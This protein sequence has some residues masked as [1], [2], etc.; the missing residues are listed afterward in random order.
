MT[1]KF[2]L[3]ILLWL[4]LLSPQLAA[5][6]E[7]NY[8][9]KHSGFSAST[10]QQPVFWLDNDRVIF[11]GH[12]VFPEK[13]R[14]DADPLLEQ[15]I[16]IWDTRN[17][18]V[19]NFAK[20]ASLGCYFQGYIRYRVGLEAKK[21]LM[22]KERTYVTWT[23]D[24]KYTYVQETWKG[25]P[26]ESHDQQEVRSHRIT[27]RSYKPRGMPADYVELLPEH[28]YLSFKFSLL[29]PPPGPSMPITWYRPGASEGTKLPLT[30]AQVNS[31]LV[32]YLEFVQAYLLY[33]HNYFDP[34]TG[35]DSAD[36]PKELPK[37]FW[38]MKP[39][40][41]VTTHQV[42]N[43]YGSWRHVRPLRHG[44]FGFGGVGS[45]GKIPRNPGNAGAYWI[46]GDHA[47]RLSA[48]LVNIMAVSPDGCKVA[49]VNE[50][51]DELPMRDRV[52]LHALD[53][54]LGG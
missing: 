38:L 4:L 14:K 16:Y 43:I 3:I 32:Y 24:R 29:E 9:L 48:G 10:Q 50:P 19:D 47:H 1:H 42:P 30:Y 34:V 2:S 41:T 31:G 51:H 49:F 7:R 27:C 15:G 53:V 39:D 23:E 25:E 8:V 17:N 13:K 18:H 21:G 5:C 46:D 52:T 35:R 44:V 33:S 26:P 37:V 20:D 12:Q 11:T 54:C 28:G 22:G 45:V 36:W 40:G 6:G